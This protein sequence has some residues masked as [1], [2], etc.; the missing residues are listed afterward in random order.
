[1]RTTV[2]PDLAVDAGLVDALAA[3]L[4]APPDLRKAKLDDLAHRVRLA[5]R[6]HE[7]VGRV[8]LQDPVHALD[9]VAR[10]APVA[11]GLEIAEI[12]RFLQAGLDARDARG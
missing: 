3:P 6:Q 1:M 7:I 9:I 2:L 11:L 5:G 10:M 8:G 12:E 4:D